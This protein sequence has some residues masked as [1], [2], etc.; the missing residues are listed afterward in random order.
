[1]KIYYVDTNVFLRFLLNDIPAQYAIVEELFNKAK[2]EKV[3][4]VVPQIIIFEIQFVL[5]TLY[6]LSKPEIIENIQSKTIQVKNRS[7]EYH[8]SDSSSDLWK[9]LRIWSNLVKEGVEFDSKGKINLKK[10]LLC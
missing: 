7:E 1:M 5:A 8:F 3:K 2:N 4:L 9:T 10:H 6:H